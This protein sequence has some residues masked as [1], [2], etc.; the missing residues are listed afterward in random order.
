MLIHLLY[1]SSSQILAE[2]TWCDFSNSHLCSPQPPTQVLI[3]LLNL[4]FLAQK[5]I[6]VLFIS[7]LYCFPFIQSSLFINCLTSREA[8]SY[9]WCLVFF[10]LIPYTNHFHDILLWYFRTMFHLPQWGRTFI[11][12]HFS[13]FLQYWGFEVRTWWLLHRCCTI[14]TTPAAYYNNAGELFLSG[15]SGHPCLLGSPRNLELS[16]QAPSLL[17]NE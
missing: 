6:S 12:F 13:I 16:M 2:L 15:F 3:L 17:S 11:I 10:F 14:W 5:I 1:G 7:Y 8:E 9:Y 4:F